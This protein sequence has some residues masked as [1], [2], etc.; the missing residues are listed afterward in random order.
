MTKRYR[1]NFNPN[2]P[3]LPQETFF[4]LPAPPPPQIIELF[5]DQ[6]NKQHERDM[7]FI[8][9]HEKQV[10]IWTKDI[11]H[12]HLTNWIKIAILVTLAGVNVL[13]LVNKHISEYPFIY[14]LIAIVIFGLSDISKLA[15][16]LM[17][18]LKTILNK[19]IK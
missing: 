7:S 3:S 13:L 14:L 16:I 1:P 8:S 15:I 11:S 10:E 12:I 5:K 4:Q 19:F 9:I 17:Q 18:G 2:Q 6:L